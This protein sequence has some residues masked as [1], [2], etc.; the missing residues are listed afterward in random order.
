VPDGMEHMPHLLRRYNPAVN[1]EWI[2]RDGYGACFIARFG[3][4][5]ET[6]R[7]PAVEL[8]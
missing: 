8:K 6:A 1:G 5:F 3:V 7:G 4:L 2:T